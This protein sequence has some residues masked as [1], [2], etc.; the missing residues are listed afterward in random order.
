MRP[1]LILFVL[2]VCP[3]LSPAP[4]LAQ[5]R[6]DGALISVVS[7]DWNDDGMPDALVLVQGAE[8]TADLILYRGA[9]RGL[10]EQARVPGVVSTWPMLGAAPTLSALPNGSVALDSEQ[11]GF[12]RTPWH[13]RITLSWR[14]G[15]FVVS[16]FSYDW[17]DRLAEE[18]GGSC[19]VN[20]LTGAWEWQATDGP[21][22]PARQGRGQ[23]APSAFPLA[24]LAPDLFPEDC[25]RP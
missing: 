5:E 24:A 8:D 4:L 6:P 14:G 16:G 3:V 13:Q 10:E 23:S 17:Y 12:G 1:A 9:F 21:D 20:L 11:T 22:Q 18:T 15:Q 2:P 25:Q 19:S 7:G